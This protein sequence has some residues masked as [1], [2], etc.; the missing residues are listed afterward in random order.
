MDKVFNLD[1]P[2]MVF[3]TKVADLII[4]NLLAAVCCIPVITIGAS[5]TALH[6]VVL[7]IVRDEE[8]YIVKSFFKSFKEN[9][10]QATII[11][12]ILLAVLALIIG[13]FL[14]FV[15]SG[16]TF[17]GWLKAGLIALLFVVLF[18]TAHLFPVLSRFDNT[19]KNTYKNSLFM[20]ILALP[21]TILMMACWVIPVVISIYFL[22][23]FPVVICFGLSGPAWLNALLYNKTFK[24]F[25]PEEEEI[26]DE[27]FIEPIAEEETEK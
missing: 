2:V 27:W 1:S 25:E 12:L 17:P 9:F 3:L 6:Y 23:I 8:G 24:K 4:V 21:K 14:I 5:M 16:I 13:D 26:K 15:Y 19:I 11:W 22:Q 18:A 7:K 20:G 10:K